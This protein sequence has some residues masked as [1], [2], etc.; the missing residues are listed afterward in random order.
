MSRLRNWCFT[1]NNY[2]PAN[3]QTLVD[4]TDADGSDPSGH[5]IRYLNMQEEIAPDTGTPHL[6]GYME[7]NRAIT[8]TALKRALTLNGLH[9]EQRH[10]SQLQAIVYCNKDESRAPDG[11]QW[12]IGLK[13][14]ETKAVQ[15]VIDN[16]PMRE[17]ALEH[18]NDYVRHFRGFTALRNVIALPRT[19]QMEILIFVGR[20]GTGKS[21]SAYHDYPEAYTAP[22]PHKHGVWWW[23]SYDGQETV[24]LDEFRHQIPF[25]KMLQILDRYTFTV[26]CKGGNIAFTSRRIVFTTNIEPL[27]WYPDE[28][29]REP[30]LRRFRD[31]TK[32]Y[33]FG[34]IEFDNDGL[35]VVHKTLRIDPDASDDES[36]DIRMEIDDE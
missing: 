17:I 4:N 13:K 31:Y 14:R 28:P 27:E 6:Q 32:I 36:D 25:G 29:E 22:W 7:C 35:P 21:Y 10:G 8:M 20:T 1:L 26:Q 30:L 24:I 3:I 16:E 15:M 34:R 19:W 18:P 12:A 23:P 11:R 2:T 9:L 33:D 5:L